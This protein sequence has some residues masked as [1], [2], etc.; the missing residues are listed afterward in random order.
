[1]ASHG[2]VTESG[3]RSASTSPFP[4]AHNQTA[5]ACGWTNISSLCLSLFRSQRTGGLAQV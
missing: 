3:W 5:Q 2:A 4:C 1:V